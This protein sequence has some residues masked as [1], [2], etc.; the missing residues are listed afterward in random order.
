MEISFTMLRPPSAPTTPT[1]F[2]FTPAGSFAT[3][4]MVP[5]FLSTT[6]R[7]APS[8]PAG[9]AVDIR[10]RNS[11]DPMVLIRLLES[12]ARSE[13]PRLSSFPPCEFPHIGGGRRSTLMVVQGR[14]A[15]HGNKQGD[16][17]MTKLNVTAIL[18][19][20][21]AA[22]A[23]TIAASGSALAHGGMGS[24]MG[25]WGGTIGHNTLVAEKTVPV[26]T[27]NPTKTVTKTEKVIRID[28]DRRRVRFGRFGYLGVDVVAAP[29]PACFYKWTGL[30]RVRICP[31]F[32]Y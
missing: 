7:P 32:P 12:D 24:H 4:S 15:S 18:A 14:S 19:G 11:A 31:D 1:N 3:A 20:A 21:A 6:G 2:S 22:A 5:A 29:V 10:D 16:E 9:K 27:V 23:I 13:P 25:G 30:G 28:R 8:G 17:T 26:K